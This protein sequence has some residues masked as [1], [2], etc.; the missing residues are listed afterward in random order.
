MREG[1]P[2]FHGQREGF[3]CSAR[4][5]AERSCMQVL[6]R[7]TRMQVIQLG[8]RFSRNG[9]LVLEVYVAGS[10]LCYTQ[11]QTGK[12]QETMLS[13]INA[14]CHAEIRKVD[15]SDIPDVPGV[16]IFLL[17]TLSQCMGG[18]TCAAD[19]LYFQPYF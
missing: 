15:Q 7:Y 12:S 5:V 10:E 2:V 11:M 9:A 1:S 18:L 16:Q 4:E 13:N 6:E 3:R 14:Q 8:L 17:L 19:P